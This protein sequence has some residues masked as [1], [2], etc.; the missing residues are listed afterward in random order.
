MTASSNTTWPYMLIQWYRP[1]TVFRIGW[2]NSKGPQEMLG[3]EGKKEDM[4]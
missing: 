2:P 1:N 3:E 4:L